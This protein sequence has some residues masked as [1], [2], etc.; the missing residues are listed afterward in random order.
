MIAIRGD[1]SEWDDLTEA[2]GRAVQAVVRGIDAHDDI[3]RGRAEREWDH[4]PAW[5]RVEDLARAGHDADTIESLVDS[6]P[7]WLE[8]CDL[9]GGR[10]VTLTPWA[11]EC[12][13]LETRDFWE[14]VDTVEPP[15][16]A[17]PGKP[18]HV[19]NLVELPRWVPVPPPR[20]PGSPRPP[21]VCITLP[22][23]HHTCRLPDWLDP[24]WVGT[25]AIAKATTSKEMSPLDELIA[26]EEIERKHYVV[27]EKVKEDGSLEVDPE[28]G[29]VKLERLTIRGQEVPRK[30]KPAKRGKHR[31]K[32]KAKGAESAVA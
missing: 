16:K 27:Q 22:E 12:L 30:R 6:E 4:R 21:K 28:T 2:Q 11:A 29:R 32:P 7:A 15:P 18:L 23:R 25:K 9:P 5:S 26:Q 13:R 10:V 14:Y 8:E 1:L 24:L 17:K 19:E 31:R 3:R 20:E